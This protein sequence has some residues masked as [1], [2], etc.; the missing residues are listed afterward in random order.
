MPVQGLV[1]AVWGP[2]L[3]LVYYSDYAWYSAMF[4]NTVPLTK[5]TYTHVQAPPFNASAECAY[6]RHV[7]K[8]KMVHVDSTLSAGCH[9]TW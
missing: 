3:S 8:H 4:H 7:Q 2:V 5:N 1:T 9:C 6:C